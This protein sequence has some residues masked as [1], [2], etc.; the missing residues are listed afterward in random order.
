MHK[1]LDIIDRLT[2]VIAMST[3]EGNTN[4][5]SVDYKLASDEA[6]QVLIE[7]PKQCHKQWHSVPRRAPY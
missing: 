7:V 6:L 1:Q 2:K 4:S 5:I 3:S